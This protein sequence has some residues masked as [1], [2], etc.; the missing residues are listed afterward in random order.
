MTWHYIFANASHRLL[1]YQRLT[2]HTRPA[3]V[4]D[5]CDIVKMKRWQEQGL[6]IAAKWF[7][8]GGCAEG[9]DQAEQRQIAERAPEHRHGADQRHRYRHD[10]NDGSAPGLQEQDHHESTTTIASAMISVTASMDCWMN[11]VGL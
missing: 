5:Q 9:E 7:E 6:C 10:R 2:A 11:S 8:Y 4:E 1:K 3:T